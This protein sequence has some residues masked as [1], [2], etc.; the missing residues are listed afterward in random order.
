[1]VVMETTIAT[2]ITTRVATRTVST[3]TMCLEF[4]MPCGVEDEQ[5]TGGTMEVNHNVLKRA[6]RWRADDDEVD[7]RPVRNNIDDEEADRRHIPPLRGVNFGEV[8]EEADCGLVPPLRGVNFRVEEAKCRH[9]PPLRG[10]NFWLFEE[11]AR[12]HIPPL[13]GVNFGRVDR[14][15]QH[16]R[17]SVKG[18]ITCRLTT[19]KL[20][21]LWQQTYLR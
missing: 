8:A 19:A 1:M 15:P 4:S 14:R 20:C 21:V 9:I 6:A 10:V 18:L 7:W 16:K 3:T 2:M 11:A 17:N 5:T 13:R 12:Q